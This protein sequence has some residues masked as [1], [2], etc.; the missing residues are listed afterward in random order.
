MQEENISENQLHPDGPK[1]NNCNLDY[2]FELTLTNYINMRNR[3][4]RRQK[5]S[6]IILVYYSFMLIL[7]E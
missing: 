6:E 3:L 7:N 2:R 5:F 4:Y 1:F